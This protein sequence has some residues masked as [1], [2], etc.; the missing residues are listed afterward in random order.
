MTYFKQSFIILAVIVSLTKVGIAQ[1]NTNKEVL[2]R[3]YLTETDKDIQSRTLAYQK[4][5]KYG[6]P[7]VLENK[8]LHQF[9]VLKGIDCFG[10]PVYVGT[11]GN[12]SA[13]T[14]STN[15][16][17]QQY[18]VSGSSTNMLDKLA[19][20]DGGTVNK[21]HVE[22]IGRILQ[23]DSA[24][25]IHTSDDHATHTSGTMIAA[26]INPSAKGMSYAAQQLIVY[27]FIN[28]F[29]EVSKEAPNLLLSNHSYGTNAGWLLNG[30]WF[31][32]GNP[33]SLSD[34]KF[35]FYGQEAQT[36]DS[37]LY[38]APGY[39][40]VQAA[41]NSRNSN[42]PAVGSTYQYYSPL[43]SSTILT[44][45]RGAGI[46]SNDSF[47]TIPTYA[48]AK[49]I[50]TVGAVSGLQ[51]G[52]TLPS[53]VEMTN[54]SSW[55][56][57]S[58]GRIKPDLVAD[59][60]GV[61]SCVAS[62]NNAYAVYNGTSMATP[63]ITGSL[64]LIQE[65]YSKK[66]NGSFMRSASLKGLAIHTA[67]EAGAY[68]GPDYKYGWGLMNTKKAADFVTNIYNS[69]TIIEQVLNNTDTF[70]YSFVASG[71][72]PIKATL[73]WTDAP[74]G[75]N[76]AH[77]YNNPETKLI[78][79]LD[80]VVI[81]NSTTYHPWVLNPNL[82]NQAAF[83]GVNNLDNVE[84]VDIDTTIPGNLYTVI[85]THKGSLQRGSQAFSLILSGINGDSACASY[86]TNNA[87]L[88][89]DS[90]SVTNLHVKN[91]S[92]CTTYTDN[93]KYVACIEPHQN[94]AFTVYTGNC[95]GITNA[96][97]VVKLYV[98]YNHNGTYS[99][100]GELVATSAVLTGKT[101][102]SGSFTTPWTLQPGAKTTMR[103]VAV[104]TTDTS[105]VK[106]C[107]TYAKGETQDISL[108]VVAP[109]NDIA[110]TDIVAPVDSSCNGSTLLAVQLYN[111]GTAVQNK[112]PL[113]VVVKNG[114]TVISTQS[115]TCNVIAHPQDIFTYTLPA[116]I[117]L[118]AST[119]Y[120]ISAV[121]SLVND[122]DTT[123]N[124]F[125]KTL[126]TA[127]PVTTP[128]GIG[129]ICV[130][131]GYALLEV[132]NS[133]PGVNYFW[134]NSSTSD[135]PVASGTT[136][137]SNNIPANN[138][139]YLTSGLNTSGIG[140]SSK[141]LF[142][143]GGGYLP[144][145][146]NTNYI[147]YNSNTNVILQSAKLYTGYPGK[148]T[149]SMGDFAGTTFVPTSSVAIN[150]PATLATPVKGAY[151]LN[152]PADTGAVYSLNLPLTAGAHYIV[153][154]TD[155]SATVFCN[156][157]VTGSPYPMGNQ[158][159]LAILS[160]SGATYQS[161]YLALYAMKFTT[162]DCPSSRV[163]VI[164]NNANPPVI[165]QSHDTLFSSNMLNNQWFENGGPLFM[166]NNYYFVAA[167]S[168][169]YTVSCSDSMGCTQTSNG[170]LF[171]SSMIF[172]TVHTGHDSLYGFTIYPV[173]VINHLM[174]IRFSMIGSSDMKLSLFNPLGQLCM[175]KDY[176][177]VTGNFDQQIWV[178]NLSSGVYY[179]YI[180][181][182]NGT[183]K[184]AI[185]IIR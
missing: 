8:E 93:R 24:N 80:I 62:S 72:D 137:N 26:G 127:G 157:N 22:L 132:T 17:W 146:G 172:D 61:T 131:N 107:G 90:L 73:A 4:A 5:K 174:G 117:T 145:T 96:S 175:Y 115:V 31:F 94:V 44:G 10:F 177:S 185:R 101:I 129:E 91:T 125:T 82:P 51:Y 9:S 171:D 99:D 11:L 155:T 183:L 138:T 173:P 54:F 164:A 50:L 30:S 116:S 150:V 139:F 123:N 111:K 147:R 52:Y 105:S 144:L 57:T 176:P 163:T 104:E 142:P 135:V 75:I 128:S 151:A 19:I 32:Y 119:S 13:N 141:N 67:D 46:S 35:G 166:E 23:K 108:Q 152:D 81:N 48:N 84:R 182:K 118:A 45:T 76:Y 102:Y 124:S 40:I 38:N 77:R 66:H 49:N 109:S 170:F 112:I 74:A 134:Y 1:T 70:R 154:S 98:D 41:G 27:D 161:D 100:P 140:L 65:L 79:D 153:I 33:D 86:P 3:M 149:I 37:I 85:I 56:P 158:N 25:S 55:G 16:V 114:N 21:N 47:Y 43:D 87:G 103:I 159:E 122:Q 162:A 7:L 143:G 39:L 53:D 179:L 60:V 58:D 178:G 59:G 136:A 133:K 29:A 156:N 12:I 167:D 71:S 126:V 88:T 42:G 160:N 6:W 68:P 121:A 15:Q 184:R 20:W 180:R 95:S 14:I 168:A 78:N 181:F 89:I 106:P 148:I 120:T 169:V 130:T 113:S 2:Q 92:G 83:K 18:S 69:D 63:S 110:V 165:T 28:D 36:W 64:F 34:Y 97:S